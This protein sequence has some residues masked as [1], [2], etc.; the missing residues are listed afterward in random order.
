MTSQYAPRNTTALPPS[1]AA[2][3][4]DSGY[5]SSVASSVTD[6]EHL[7]PMTILDPTQQSMFF[8]RFF[9]LGARRSYAVWGWVGVVGLGRVGVQMEMMRFL[10]LTRAPQPKF[11]GDNGPAMFTSYISTFFAA[12]MSE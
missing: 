4:V 2:T 1:I 8:F 10:L 3:R 5:G 7:P 11:R 12:A 6:G 9:F